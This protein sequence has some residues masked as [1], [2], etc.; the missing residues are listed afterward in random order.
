MVSIPDSPALN[1]G[2]NSIGVDIDPEYCRMALR[3]LDSESIPFFAQAAIE[4]RTATDLLAPAAIPAVADRP[5][6]LRS[7]RRRP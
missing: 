2:R 4:Y 3:R 6:R 1:N 7:G 5:S